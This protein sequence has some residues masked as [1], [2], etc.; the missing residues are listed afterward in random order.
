[1]KYR[2]SVVAQDQ[3]VALSS[4]TTFDLPVNPLSFLI[5]TM[6]FLNVT[7]EATLAQILARITTLTVTR[8]GSTIFSASGADMH[9]LNAL[10]FKQ[11]PILTNQVA[12]D[13]AARYITMFVPFS[14]EAYNPAEGLPATQRGELK[15]QIEMSAS[16]ADVDNVSFQIEA[17]EML[18]ATP[19]QYLKTT[20]LSLTPVSG[21]E[22][23]AV[24]PIGNKLA[25]IGLFS[26]T[27][28]TGTAFTASVD[29]VRLLINNVEDT[30]A[31]ANWESIHGELLRTI[32]HRQDYD[33]SADN[34]DLSLYGLLD[35]QPLG[36]DS[37]LVET[38]G[39]SSCVLKI[40]G[41]DTN[42]IRVFPLEIVAI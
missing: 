1:M 4:I 10:I 16:E 32:G 15:L 40:T 25:G 19:K 2:R 18:G 41:G 12:T 42:A 17:V 7:D 20:T 5:V 22:N 28:P 27:V 23:D 33:A 24:L 13:N 21:V 26:T 3:A 39:A 34:D 31:A 8:F 9:K 38:K 30:I 14:R 29:K 35:F 11:L 6:R 37:Y 36:D